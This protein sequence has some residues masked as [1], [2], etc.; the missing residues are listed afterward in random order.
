MA[1][2]YFY[3][4]SMNAGKST[5]LLQSSYNYRERGMNTLVLAPALD[6]RFGA[7]K[8]TSRIGIETDARTFAPE[9]DLLAL[10]E[11]R[12]KHSQVHCVL[13]DEAHAMPEDALE[14]VRLL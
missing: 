10:V 2:L 9:D 7:G 4:S 3:Y 13:I 11:A 5:A 12:N 8:V 14:Q 1:K 6:D